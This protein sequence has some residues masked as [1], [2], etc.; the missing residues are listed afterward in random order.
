MQVTG[1]SEEQKQ[2]KPDDIGFR[3]GPRINAVGRIGEP[4]IAIELLTTDDSKIALERAMQCEQINNKR[5]EICEHIELE[6]IHLI[7]NTPILWKRDRV[8]VVIKSQ[9]HHGVIGIVASRLVERYGVPVFIG[10][11]EE[12][13]SKIR[14]SARGIKEFNVIE[15][16]I[17]V[18]IF[19]KNMEDIK[20]QVDSVY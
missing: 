13:S 3:L 11:Y 4:Q 12:N 18:K 9:W 17:F 10:T 19:W 1:I 5:K 7:E 8:L 6:A 15:G 20:Q 14:G 16:L 2:L